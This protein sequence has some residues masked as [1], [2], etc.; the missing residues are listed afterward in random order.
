[1]PLPCYRLTEFHIVTCHVSCALYTDLHP[2]CARHKCCEQCYLSFQTDKS[3]TAAFNLLALLFATRSSSISPASRVKP[4]PDMSPS[5]VNQLHQSMPSTVGWVSYFSQWT[6]V[7]C[8]AH[9][10]SAQTKG[11]HH[12][13]LSP[14]LLQGHALGWKL[15]KDTLYGCRYDACGFSPADCLHR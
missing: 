14:V 5:S 10:C 11:Q 4:R 8:S 2:R 9:P 13:V 1:M 7:I 3:S 6:G 12:R 15:L